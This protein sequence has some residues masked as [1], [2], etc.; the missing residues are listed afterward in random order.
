MTEF[1]LGAR[2]DPATGTTVPAYGFTYA[3]TFITD[4][5]ESECGRFVVKP[6]YY[7]LTEEQ[8]QELVRLNE[9]LKR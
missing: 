9:S 8:A 7:R 3:G 6:G 5:Y 2:L 1:T 4:P